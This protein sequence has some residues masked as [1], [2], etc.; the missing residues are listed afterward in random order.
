MDKLD[1]NAIIHM[2]TLEDASLIKKNIEELIAFCVKRENLTLKRDNIDQYKRLMMDKYS[3]VHQKYPTLF[4]SVIENPTTFQM[5]RLDE[6]LNL[7]KQIE[8]NQKTNEQASIVL[9]QK[10]YDEFVKDKIKNLEKK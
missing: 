1:D 4:F 6:M 3:H 9:G 5:K 10:Y 7:K 8:N 2:Q